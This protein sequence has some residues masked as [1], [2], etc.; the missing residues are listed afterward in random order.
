VRDS[1][2]NREQCGAHDHTAKV[3]KR[4]AD[5]V[6][7]ETRRVSSVAP[8]HDLI[9]LQRRAGNSAVVEFLRGRV[10]QRAG[11]RTV[12]VNGKIIRLPPASPTPGPFPGAGHRL[13]GAE[14][15]SLPRRVDR[16]RAVKQR[17][18]DEAFRIRLL[19]LAADPGSPLVADVEDV[20]S[21]LSVLFLQNPNAL[22][23]HD[24]EERRLL[25]LRLL[26]G[27]AAAFG[28]VRIRIRRL[29]KSVTSI[30]PGAPSVTKAQ[31]LLH[32]AL[33]SLR[34]RPEDAGTIENDCGHELDSLEAD[35]KVEAFRYWLTWAASQSQTTSVRRLLDELEVRLEEA[36]KMKF[37]AINSVFSTY[38]APAVAGVTQKSK[39][40]AS[41]TTS[42]PK[43]T[44]SAA[45]AKKVAVGRVHLRA[46][47][48]AAGQANAV[49][50]LFTG[51]LSGARGGYDPNIFH[52][53]VFGDATNNMIFHRDGTV[54]GFVMG[55][56]GRE[57][58]KAQERA[59]KCERRAGGE[60]VRV[61]V[62]SGILREITPG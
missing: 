1:R 2:P 22:L 23:A 24:F 14:E 15:L 28:V 7:S 18:T 6:A 59:T 51:Q 31:H 62:L 42:L 4:R 36:S 47:G 45:N 34:A 12:I 17:L 20:F 57:N 26:P 25:R 49:D 3:P 5:D 54:L 13:G 8:G 30:H 27:C 50:W 61:A 53:H 44:E 55:H 43:L 46:I 48:D 58:P 21:E 29:C 40:S 38:L 9:A 39:T 60:T 52:W 10:V 32:S 41:G 11:G 33:V 35:S 19:V 37:E 16:A 56:I